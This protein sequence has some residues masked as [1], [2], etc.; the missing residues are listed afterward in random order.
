MVAFSLWQFFPS[1]SDNYSEN[2]P[3]KASQA[4]ADTKSKLDPTNSTGVSANQDNAKS[5]HAALQG[6]WR[7]ILAEDSGRASSQDALRDTRVSIKHDEFVMEIAGRKNVSTFK[8]DPSTSPK[9]IDLKAAGRTRPG[10][11]DL[12]GDTLRIC[13][14]E[15]ADSRPTVFDSQPGSVNDV[16]LTLKRAKPAETV[17]NDNTEATNDG[18]LTEELARE[19][20]PRAASMSK[21]EFQKLQTNPSDQTL[22]SKSLSLILMT[23]DVRGQTPEAASDFKYLVDGYPKPREIAAVMSPSR[24]KGYF[25]MIQP[26]YITECKITSS[27]DEIAQGKVTFNAPKLYIGSVVFEAKKHKKEWRIEKFQLSSRQ[28]SI[29]LGEDGNWQRQAEGKD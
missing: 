16:V 13:V 26:D 3:G 24:S 23:L 11:Y 9:S 1:V 25:S 5:D 7:V 17:G 14:S 27:T 18:Q 2:S 12:Q 21:E 22:E 4:Y 20:I 10:I 29:V 28:I 19:L 8:L 6:D 15:A